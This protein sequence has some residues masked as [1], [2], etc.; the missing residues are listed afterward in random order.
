MTVATIAKTA[1]RHYFTGLSS[2]TKP[3]ATTV[4]PGSEFWA[5]DTSTLYRNSGVAWEAVIKQTSITS[6]YRGQYPQTW[7]LEF[8]GAVG[9]NDNDTVYTSPDISMY[10]THYIEGTAGTVDVQV[11]VDGTNFNTTPA[12]V[13]L[14]DATASAT[15]SATIA[16]GKLGILRGKYKAIKI[17]QNG[18]TAANARGAHTHS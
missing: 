18:A 15:Y 12:V 1:S 6:D 3:S 10:D 16:S 8:T 4:P 5:Y 7:R 14:H 2:D 17:L 11:S 13:Q 9:T